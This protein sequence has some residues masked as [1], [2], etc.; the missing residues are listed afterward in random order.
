[1]SDL[2]AAFSFLKD[3]IGLLFAAGQ[4]A[5]ADWL[6]KLIDQARQLV[7]G[8]IAADDAKNKLLKAGSFD[9]F[10]DFD[11]QAFKD[12]LNQKGETGL[13]TAIGIIRDIA[14]DLAKVWTSVLVP[15]GQL[16]I[17]GFNA[18]ADA[19]N[20][21]FGTDISGRFLIIVTVLG[22]VSG[23]F[24]LLGTALA[25]IGT[26]FGFLLS[27]FATL[28]PLLLGAGAIVRAFWAEFRLGGTAAITAVRTEQA[29]FLAGFAELARGNFTVAWDLFRTAGLAAFA[30]LKS[31]LSEMFGAGGSTFGAIRGLISGLS[32]AAA[33]LAAIFNA[34]FGTNIGTGGLLLVAIITQLTG[35]FGALVVAGRLLAA[36]FTTI[37]AGLFVVIAS[38]V[39]LSRVFPDIGKSWTLVTDAFANLLAG[40]FS[41]AFQQLGQAFSGVWSNL[42]DQGVLTWA[43]LGAGA[44][45][46]AGA[47][48]G[49]IEKFKALSFLLTATA[50]SV[51]SIVAG[52]VAAGII[53]ADV[54]QGIDPAQKKIEEINS[55]FAKGQI[56]LEEYNKRLQDLANSAGDAAAKTGDAAAKTGDTAQ[57]FGETWKQA[58]SKINEAMRGTAAT[59][60][61]TAGQVAAPWNQAAQQI[62]GGFK[63]I[64]KGVWQKIPDG[65]RDAADQS[66]ATMKALPGRVDGGFKEIGKGIWQKIPD[67]A[68]T[69]ADQ[70]AQTVNALP[71]KV[72]DVGARLQDEFNRF[73]GGDA[74]PLG[75]VTQSG[76]SDS[77]W[78]HI[79]DA[80]TSNLQKADEALQAF[81]KASG[82]AAGSV[83]QSFA[84]L[85]DIR[86]PDW[87]NSA[88]KN[89][90][91]LVTPPAS[92][93]ANP[94]GDQLT[95]ASSDADQLAAA[96]ETAG[97]AVT[98]IGT[99]A[100][101]AAAGVTQ[102]GQGAAAIDQ[103]FG[104]LGGSADTFAQ[105]F[106]AA[107]SAIKSG[108]DGIGAALD[109]V[110]AKLQAAGDAARQ[111]AQAAPAATAAAD[112]A[113]SSGDGSTPAPGFAAGGFTGNIGRSRIAGVVHGNEHVQPAW[114][115]ARPGV[116][117]FL[118]MLRHS[119]DLAATIS[120]FVGGFSMGGFV[121]GLSR[122]FST[123]AL[124]GYAN[125]GLVA[126]NPEMAV[127]RSGGLHPVTLDLG[128]GRQVGGLFAP[129]DVV[130]QLKRKVVLERMVTSGR[131]PG[132]G[133]F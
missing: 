44:I 35:G 130:E 70:A 37:G 111:L 75:A 23:A 42:Q 66:A 25:P 107:V 29:G 55:A 94:F 92:G 98:A 124:P 21:T 80:V 30:T 56:T 1:M 77:T 102:L 74:L 118:E 110:I 78:E 116:L 52:L 108:S 63:E 68:K 125:G 59:S 99:D 61:E 106:E 33:G 86:L 17:A 104:A 14:L 60:S 88:L 46:V 79:K 50:A 114:V 16:V 85:N 6:T 38:A 117:G 90:G 24:G 51:A 41:K 119:G 54:S 48:A 113:A 89:P 120:R 87:L 7:F 8:F 121:D 5:R 105:R 131:R 64:G 133:N 81:Q 3:K 71:D 2:A 4:T 36:L 112:S 49:L 67:G 109:G 40:D 45:A 62:Q 69:A 10:K 22:L 57:G 84:G 34:I 82:D 12:F 83:Q 97:T 96:A 9:F 123:A 101:A 95:K 91:S 18:I 11:L 115:V 122:S 132:R 128:G 20:A 93:A 19:I 58:L 13:A 26:L 32:L 126:F 73:F 47:V 72:K 129:P 28:G 15:A 100:T 27:S 43:I 76:F 103:N 39:I 53:A 65:A 127:A 31:A